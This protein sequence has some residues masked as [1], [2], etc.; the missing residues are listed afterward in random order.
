MEE[1]GSFVLWPNISPMEQLKMLTEWKGEWITE[2]MMTS[3]SS[4]EI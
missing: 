3:V 1:M 4:P 2:V